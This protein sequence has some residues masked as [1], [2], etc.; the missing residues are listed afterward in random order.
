ML[1]AEEMK[2]LNF[3]REKRQEILFSVM[4]RAFLEKTNKNLREVPRTRQKL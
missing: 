1:D 2:Q 4:T 3:T